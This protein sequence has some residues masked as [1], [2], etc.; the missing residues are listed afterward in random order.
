M[1]WF[2]KMALGASMILAINLGLAATD[3]CPGQ[4]QAL[5]SYIG[6]VALAIGDVSVA[7]SA[8]QNV[9]DTVV[10]DLLSQGVNTLQNAC[11]AEASGAKTASKR[12]VSKKTTGGAVVSQ[13]CYGALTGYQAYIKSIN[14]AGASVSAIIQGLFMGKPANAD[15]F[16]NCHC[17]GSG[18]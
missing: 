4:M 15:Y 1:Q 16:D 13:A 6:G 17:T 12:A 14:V 18:N 8:N 11:Q 3:S 10:C 2:V 7:T 5:Q 9:S